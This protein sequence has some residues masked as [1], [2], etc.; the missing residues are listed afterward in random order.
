MLASLHVAIPA[1]YSG[2]VDYIK[3]PIDQI[4]LIAGSLL[5]AAGST[6]QLLQDMRSVQAVFVG[7]IEKARGE[8]LREE[9][10]RR[11][12]KDR[13][14]P[15]HYKKRVGK[16]L[17]KVDLALTRE[18]R[19]LIEK[20]EQTMFGWALLLTGALATCAGSAPGPVPVQFG[21]FLG[22][23]AVFAV[24]MVV[25]NRPKDGEASKV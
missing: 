23:L 20:R 25:F 5:I 9:I 21:V 8:L 12:W 4:W 1:S 11:G 7:R 18:E 17:A 3:E 15:W 13:L 19:A 24:C 16:A 22:L 6:V 2:Y 10:G 14:L